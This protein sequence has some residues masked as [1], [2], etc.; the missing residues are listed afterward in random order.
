MAGSSRPGTAQPDTLRAGVVAALTWVAAEQL[1][2]PDLVGVPFVP[3]LPIAAL[4]GAAVGRFGGIRWL[5]GAASAL[6]LLM[7]SVAFTPILRGPVHGL[8]VADSVPV[9]GV[10]AIMVLSAAVSRDSLLSPGGAERLLHGI[11]LLNEGRAAVLVTSRVWHRQ[12]ADRIPS[13]T[14]QARLRALAPDSVRWVVIDSVATSRDEAVQTAALARREGWSRL[15]VV[16]SPLHTRRA[17]A[18]FRKVGLEVTCVPAPSRGIAVRS[19]GTAS[20]RLAAF[21]PWLYETVGW[22]WYRARGWV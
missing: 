13:D 12:G 15:I 16:T 14:D 10:D 9:D 11:T 6:L 5:F 21:G 18:A 7:L 2:L 3:A 1:G 4:L 8:I 17:C 22:W 19:L 20:D